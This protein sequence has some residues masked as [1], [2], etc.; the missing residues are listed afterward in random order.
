VRVHERCDTPVEYL[1]THQWFVRVLDFKAELLEAG[2]QVAWHP[3]HMQGRYRE[4]VED[5]RW[6]WCISRQRFFG[7]T[8][9][10]W[11]CAQCGEVML[12]EESQLPVDPTDQ[13]PLHP[14]ACGST[15]FTPEEDVMDTWATS[16]LSPQIVG[17]WLSDR[18]LYNRVFPMSLRPQA[19]E[20]I[21]TWAFY[22]IV[23]SRHHFGRLPW[24]AVAISGWGLAPGGTGKISKSRGGGP[25][26]P[27][28]MIE[29]TS[30]DAVRY[31]AASTGFGKDA[32]IN[33]EKIQSGS[34]LVIK[35]WNVARF[36]ERFLID[37]RAPDL[38]HSLSPADR[39]ILSRTQRLIQRVTQLF[40]GYDYATAKSEIENFFWTD[41][42]GNYLEMCKQRLYDASDTTHAGARFTLYHVLL[43]T[44]K[45]LAPFLPHVTEEVYQGLFAPSDG[46]RSIH[47]SRWPRVNE[48]FLDDQAEAAGMALVDI[49]TAVRRYKSK[50]G[51]ALGAELARLQLAA[52]D[53]AL[54][55]TLYEAVSDLMSVTRAK[56]IEV[57]VSLDSD[58]EKVKEDGSVRVA[59]AR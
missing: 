36:A 8:F 28:A 57:N 35:L 15:S 32:V 59:L 33:E 52:D 37:Y 10:V 11:Y 40:T 29:R 51:L 54:A 27:M 25:I 43:A 30:A 20:I 22:T 12:A 41:L 49:A 4:W 42:T 48:S 18:G 19:H 53:P 47:L 56:Q 14:C 16:S 23:K 17:K 9:P 13:Q 5:L 2:E 39:W 34:K 1:V 26:A 46:A 31:W 58:L 50:R 44:T 38:L 3:P 24:K 7:V 45:L 55:R 21:R 6:D